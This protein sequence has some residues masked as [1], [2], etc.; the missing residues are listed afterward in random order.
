MLIGYARVSTEDQDLSVQRQALGAARSCEARRCRR[1]P[2]PRS[3]GAVNPRS[4]RDCRVSGWRGS[5]QTGI[6]RRSSDR[7][8]TA[9]PTN[10]PP[11]RSQNLESKSVGDANGE[12]TSAGRGSSRRVWSQRRLESATM[13]LTP[14]S[15]IHVAGQSDSK[16]E[17]ADSKVGVAVRKS[18][19][20]KF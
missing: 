1:S 6:A 7:T 3:A 8:T 15:A 12:R 9:A 18:R 14:N 11:N 17:E 19:D 13:S 4:A 20:G 16:K 10:A 2:A 5:R